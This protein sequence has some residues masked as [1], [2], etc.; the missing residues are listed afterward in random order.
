M[1][2][3]FM[4]DNLNFPLQI[5]YIISSDNAENGDLIDI[6]NQAKRLNKI[7]LLIL[8]ANKAPVK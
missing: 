3:N 7:T 4:T 8:D 6:I 2:S 1:K 5:I